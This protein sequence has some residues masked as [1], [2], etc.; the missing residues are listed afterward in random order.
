MN[1][2]LLAW[3]CKGQ[4]SCTVW[5]QYSV[6]L[7]IN[8][9]Q[10]SLWCCICLME[11]DLAGEC[12]CVTCCIPGLWLS[13]S[14]KAKFTV[15]LCYTLWLS[16]SLKAKFT[17]MLYL[18]NGSWL[19]RECSCVTCCIPGLWLSQSLKA[20]FTVMLCLSN[21]SWFSRRVLLCY[22]HRY[23]FVVITFPEGKVHCDVVFV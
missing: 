9:H 5:L 3:L 12:S 1:L 21:G 19:S 4:S 7:M 13:Q 20:K 6:S 14:L 17:V 22:M 8:V 23:W 2:H 18:S 15:M 11:V 10:S 16:Q